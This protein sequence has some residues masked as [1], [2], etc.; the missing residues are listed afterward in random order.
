[1]SLLDNNSVETLR[2]Q[3]PEELGRQRVYEFAEALVLLERS[4]NAMG[5]SLTDEFPTQQVVPQSKEVA[6]YQVKHEAPAV[7]AQT[8]HVTKETASLM[9]NRAR[10]VAQNTAYS[11]D[12][13]PITFLEGK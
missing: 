8:E 9:E 10:E 11:G 12:E 2:L 1:M 7:V 3:A 6:E 4:L 5:L 13:Y